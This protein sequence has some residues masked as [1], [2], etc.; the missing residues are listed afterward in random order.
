MKRIIFFL[1]LSMATR[2][3]GQVTSGIVEY[4]ITTVDTV[5]GSTDQVPDSI[6]YTYKFK[7]SYI[8][9]TYGTSNYY[10]NLTRNSNGL[11]TISV[12]FTDKRYHLESFTYDMDSLLDFTDTMTQR[13]IITSE[14]KLIKGYSC[15]KAIVTD[16]SLHDN[17]EVVK[18]I[19]FTDQIAGNHFIAGAGVGHL[20]LNGL[21]LGYDVPYVNGWTYIY[22]S[23]ITLTGLSDSEFEPD[24]SG[25]IQ[26]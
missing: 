26:E 21:I 22:P 25:Y 7:G 15:T 14:K 18:I 13:V 24:L 8:S 6:K 3:Q 16:I 2:I 9:M 23:V 1:V 20:N 19:W 5:N 17:S 4:N 10:Q 11:Y 12:S